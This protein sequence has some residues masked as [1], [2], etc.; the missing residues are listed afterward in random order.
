MFDFIGVYG[1]SNASYSLLVTEDTNTLIKLMINHPQRI[2]ITSTTNIITTND[3]IRYFQ[4][5]PPN[6][7]DDVTISITS[8]SNS[9]IDLY[10]QIYNISSSDFNNYNNIDNTDNTNSN[11]NNYPNPNDPNSYKYSTVN[12]QSDL[13]VI[14]DNYLYPITYIITAVPRTTT[15]TS[16]EVST[17]SE[18]SIDFNSMNQLNNE[19]TILYIITAS[20][21]NQ[22]IL[23]QTGISY[24]AY[25]EQGQMSYFK[26][27]PSI[28]SLDI[29]I[30]VIARSG[31]PDMII[32]YN[33]EF[34]HCSSLTSSQWI[35]TCY[36]YTW[37]SRGYS[38]DQIVIS[39][40]E[41]CKSVLPFT[42]IKSNCK[43]N[44]ISL[45]NKPLY[46]GI[47]GYSA[48][49]F[50]ITASLSGLLTQLIAGKLFNCS[51]YSFIHSLTHTLT[52][53]ELSGCFIIIFYN[54]FALFVDKYIL[55]IFASHARLFV[56]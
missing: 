9:Y 52:I 26:Y 8:L 33:H 12:S 30:N 50:T 2:S 22:Q 27:Y 13:I 43:N 19:N 35:T 7:F 51:I 28:E 21:N 45:L 41:P 47:Y 20:V 53:Y 25:V 5:I 40:D 23:L 18:N 29:N 56:K 34:P 48:A 54:S 10:I 11:S 42:E 46:I 55:N 38:T 31:D 32:S 15:S 39:V 14:S 44:E 17:S 49:T 6:S 36:N 4:I 37:A 1:Y 3:Q 24:N 16:T